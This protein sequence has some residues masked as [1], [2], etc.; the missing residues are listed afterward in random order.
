MSQ[1]Q[2]VKGTRDIFPE[3]A[4][5]WKYV[6]GVVHS[7]ASLFGFS[8]IRTPVLEYTALFSRGIG[9]PPD[10]VGKVMFTLLPSSEEHMS[11]LQ[12]RDSS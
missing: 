9:A 1:Y 6:E 11:V 8:E 4:A 3:E 7:L 12:S 2:A 10:I 5:R